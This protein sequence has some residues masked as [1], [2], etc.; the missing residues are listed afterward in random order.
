MITSKQREAIKQ[1]LGGQYTKKIVDYLTEN[2]VLNKMKQP[3]AADAIR[4]IVGGHR[5]NIE[6]EQHI[7]DLIE[8]EKARKKAL[9]A[10]IKRSLK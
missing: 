7:A 3:Y 4:R 9:Q 8:V 2:G 1:V 10:K 6:I 5:P